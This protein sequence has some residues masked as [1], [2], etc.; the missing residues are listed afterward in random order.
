MKSAL[1]E[2]V[3]K[4]LYTDEMKECKIVIVHR[5]GQETR[6][7]IAGASAIGVENRFLFTTDG[8]AIPLHRIRSIVKGETVLWKK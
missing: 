1:E 4:L 7:E 6:K 5:E 3:K 8:S 2:L